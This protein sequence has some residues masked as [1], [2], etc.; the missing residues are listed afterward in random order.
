MKK[1]IF[2]ISVF[3]IILMIGLITYFQEI[4]INNLK[5]GK[6]ELNLTKLDFQKEGIAA[7]NGEWAIYKNKLL[8]PKELK[9][10]KPDAYFT[11]PGKLEKALNG[12][13]FGYMTLRLRIYA[14][15]N[16]VYGLRI[17]RMLSASKVW[18]N[19]ILQNQV[20]EIGTSYESER[21][22]YLPTY[23]YFTA[24]NGVV[25]I[26][27]ETSNFRDIFPV[28]NSIE[29]G[30]RSE[31]MNKYLLATSLDSIVIGGLFVM[32]LLCLSLF[33]RHKGNK[34]FM[35]FPILCFFIQLRCL[36]LNERIIVQLFPNMP[37]ELL[38]KT[39]ALTYY[40]WVPIYVLFLKAQFTNLPKKITT[41]SYCFGIL[42]AG[43]CIVTKNVFY[44]RLSYIGEAVLAIIIL[45]IFIFLKN[46]VK[47]REKNASISF[48]AFLIIIV[49]AANDILVNDGVSYGRYLFQIA[50]FIFA[51]LE[52]YILAVNYSDEMKKAKDL[53]DKNRVIYEKSIRDSLTGLYNRNYIEEVLNKMMKD[54]LKQKK[55]FS[56]IMFDIDHFKRINDEY[57]HLYG[58]KVIVRVSEIIKQNLRYT[59]Y[60]GR[61]GGEEFIV[62]LDNS[63]SHKASE[64]AEGIRNGIENFC[65][66]HNL[67]ITISGGV[68]ENNSSIMSETIE[69]ADRLLYMAKKNGR[70]QICSTI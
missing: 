10:E 60:A 68:Y 40:L 65:W 42:F 70:N 69:N 28:I 15:D 57:G 39:A 14:N 59:D 54:Y 9:N 35:Y 25:D 21:A 58:D 20:G 7:L 66:E 61:Y 27:I 4:K 33:Y 30:T 38:S 52:T 19:G 17:S 11:I 2:R 43:I 32:Q 13:S 24:E 6:G 18:V 56:V 12:N 46:K 26:V 29:F 63:N 37:Y 34:E 31:I 36:F 22:I 62:I 64:I 45:L 41:L 55:I 53:E 1:I 8:E 49:R 3:F 5:A 16:M 23:S 50:M 51:I 48:I 47:L 44:D 67:K